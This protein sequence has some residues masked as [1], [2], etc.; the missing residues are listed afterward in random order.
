MKYSHQLEFDFNGVL[1]NIENKCLANLD[2]N[3]DIKRKSTTFARI[4][5]KDSPIQNVVIKDIGKKIEIQINF[6]EKKKKTFWTLPSILEA[7]P[8]EVEIVKKIFAREKVLSVDSKPIIKKYHISRPCHWKLK[9]TPEGNY[10]HLEQYFYKLNREYFEDKLNNKI[11]WFSKRNVMSGR[12]R[13]KHFCLGFFCRGCFQIFINPLLDN[14]KIPEA[15]VEVIVYHEMIHAHLLETYHP[16]EKLHGKKFK[17]IYCKH[18]HT[19]YVEKFLQTQELYKIF[20]ERVN[21]RAFSRGNLK[22]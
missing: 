18:P 21:K 17:E 7:S 6:L 19:N 12:K 5:Q 1:N 14:N 2:V 9:W 16:N 11:Y 22:K 4:L 10:Y 20:S 8:Q 15:V 13:K 3:S